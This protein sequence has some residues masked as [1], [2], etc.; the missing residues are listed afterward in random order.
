VAVLTTLGVMSKNNEIVACKASGISLYRLALPLLLGGLTLAAT[1][2]ILDDV[3]LPYTN[4]RQDALRN[5]IKGKPAQT[6]TRPQRWIFGE[7]GKIYNYDLFE[8]DQ[9]LFAGLTVVGA[10]AGNLSREAARVREPRHLERIAEHLAARIRLGTRLSGRPR[11][12]LS[13]VQGHCAF[14]AGR[15]AAIFQSRSAAGLSIE[16]SP[17][18]QL[19]PGIAHCGLRRFNADRAVGM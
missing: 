18:G 16:L 14:R 12:E 10:G 2:I 7:K 5:Q 8:P 13:E 9:N 1:M 11:G 3:Y 6:Y 4:Q 19:H 17:A 15:A